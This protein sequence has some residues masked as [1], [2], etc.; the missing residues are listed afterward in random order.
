MVYHGQAT[1]VKSRTQ[2]TARSPMDIPVRAATVPARRVRAPSRKTPRTGPFKSAA[3]ESAVSSADRELPRITVRA[4]AGTYLAP[5]DRI[6]L[7]G[8]SGSEETDGER[9]HLHLGIHRGR[10]FALAGYVPDAS[11]LSAWIDPL[12]LVASSER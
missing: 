12:P 8:A 10:D 6:G 4:T 2:R 7:L 9:K 1:D 5:G 3:A 11:K